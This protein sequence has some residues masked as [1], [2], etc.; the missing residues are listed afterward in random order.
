MDKLSHNYDYLTGLYT[1]QELHSIYHSI[2]DKD[3]FHFM[4]IDIDNFKNVNDVYGHNEGDLL[5]KAIAAILKKCA[6]AAH[7]FRLGGDEF[8]LLLIK[9]YSQ[10]DLC[11]IANEIIDRITHKDGFSHISTFISASIGILYNETKCSTIDDILLKSDIAMYYAKKHDKGNYI[12]FS[13]IEEQ[14]MLEIEMEKRQLQALE[15]GEF[16][17]RYLPVIA[18]Q[19][20]KLTLSQVR[21][22]W[23]MPNGITVDQ[24]TFL[25]LFDKNGFIRQLTLWVISEVLS[26]LNEY[27]KKTQFTGNIGIRVSRLL[28]LDNE[29]PDM[30]DALSTKYGA[31]PSELDLEIDERFL[32]RDSTELFYSLKKLEE[33]GYSISIINVGANFKS[34]TY[35]DKI[36]FNSIIF[37]PSYLQN[38][39]ST[40]RGKQIIKTLLAMGRE[41]KMKVLAD[42][43]ATKEAALFLSGCG[44]NAISGSIHTQPLP[45]ADYYNYIKENT[46][47]G[48]EKTEFHFFNDF[49]SSDR[50]HK[51]KILGKN[52]TFANGIT[53]NWGSLLFPGGTFAE[54]VLELPAAILAEAS[55]TICMWLKPLVNTSWTSSIYARYQGSFCSFSPYVIG[56]N[57][58]FRISEDTDIN[59]FHDAIARHIPKDV[60]SFVCLTYDDASEISQTY[61][62]ARKASRRTDVPSLPA[63]RQIL[64]G[65]DPFQPSY[66]GYI[67]GLIFYDHVKSEDEITEIYNNFCNEPGFCGT[68]EDFW[69]E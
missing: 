33:K 21:L 26:H 4:L 1:R 62:N 47:Q 37:D 41:L 34:I 58:I 19:T 63:C 66:Q 30:L 3:H 55:Y 11:N 67:S 56:G 7:I 31:A 64:L 49:Y 44:C 42:G 16:E 32:G 40:T 8:C 54:N 60:W 25:P 23:N 28:L 2:T 45:L 68:K 27:H 48:N 50:K 17:I 53:D 12:L 43:I 10:T 59:G 9:E 29:F 15:N 57:S 38:A 24:D 65:G 35:W 46:A 22:F 20:S 5:L 39:L 52:I 18:T 51:G 36:H 61:I 14:V 13:D 69:F 6:P